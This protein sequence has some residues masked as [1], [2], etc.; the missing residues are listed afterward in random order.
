MQLE[1]I[2]CKELNLKKYLKA[3]YN[4]QGEIN[5]EYR[6]SVPSWCNDV[7][8]LGNNEKR[9]VIYARNK[10]YDNDGA[11]VT[12][13]NINTLD[14]YG[15]SKNK[16]YTESHTYSIVDLIGK[17]LNDLFYKDYLDTFR[18]LKSNILLEKIGGLSKQ[19]DLLTSGKENTM[20]Y[21]LELQKRSPYIHPYTG[22]RTVETLPF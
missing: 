15:I 6:L 5:V 10:K 17:D 11:R 9:S 1:K 7:Q 16:F 3:S 2:I 14:R 21:H 22:T 18:E 4:K 12:C 20:E 19:W 8:Y 13:K